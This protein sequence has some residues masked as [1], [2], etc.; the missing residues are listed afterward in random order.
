[1]FSIFAL[2]SDEETEV[3]EDVK[4]YQVFKLAIS[5]SFSFI[6]W[7]GWCLNSQLLGTTFTPT[8]NIELLN[9]MMGGGLSV[10][11]RF[12]RTISIFSPKMVS[13]EITFTNTGDKAIENIRI[14]DKVN[15]NK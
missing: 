4:N 11:Y 7:V 6:L 2:S 1:M 8:A 9:R 15:N 3:R 12:T 14:G 13:I 10:A 5:W